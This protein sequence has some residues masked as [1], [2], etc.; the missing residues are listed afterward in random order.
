MAVQFTAT[1]VVVPTWNQSPLRSQRRDA[2]PQVSPAVI[3]NGTHTQN[4]GGRQVETMI[5][6][7]QVIVGGVVSAVYVIR[8]TP[9]AWFP[10]ASLAR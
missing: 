1:G 4:P 7:G 5:V 3:P 9:V 2:A 10:Q 8:W 6:A